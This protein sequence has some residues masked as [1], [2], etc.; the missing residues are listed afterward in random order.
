MVCMTCMA[1]SPC[2][3][4]CLQ[5]DNDGNVVGYPLL[6]DINASHQRLLQV[7]LGVVPAPQAFTMSSRMSDTCAASLC[8]YIASVC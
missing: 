6:F 2:A 4:V 5:Y 8:K 7:C 1:V 3:L